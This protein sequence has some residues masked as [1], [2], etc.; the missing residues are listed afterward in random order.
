MIII[1]I[2]ITNYYIKF[3]L[4]SVMILCCFKFSY[5]ND[6]NEAWICIVKRGYL[7]NC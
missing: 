7:K 5:T 4:F 2:I 3:I 6:W 1:T